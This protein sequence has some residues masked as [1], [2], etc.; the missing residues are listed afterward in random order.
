MNVS[1]QSTV[2]GV[3]HD[4]TQAQEAVRALKAAGF[5]DE[6]IG[7]VA[8]DGTAGTATPAAKGSHVTEG[9]VAGVAA[10]AGVGALWALGIAANVLP[11]IGPVISGGIIA[12]LL[13]SA[14]GGAAIAGIG[15][16]LVGLGIP[17]ADAKHYE[18]EF[19]AGRTL[20]TVRAEGRSAE[21]WT[22]MHRH[23]AYNR[24][25][26]AV[27]THETATAA[28]STAAGQTVRLHEEQLHATKTPVKTGEVHVHKEV[29][30]EQKNIRV[31]VTR[32]EVVIEHRSAS[33]RATGGTV[34]AE[35]IR[36]PVSEEQVH[37]RKDTV[38]TG[39]VSVGKR[40]V[41]D[42][43]QVSGTVRKEEVRVE[44]EGNVEVHDS[45]GGRGT[46]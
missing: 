12:S 38:V 17:E 32:E 14:A 15:G 39:E 42:T 10:G 36:I 2:V 44:K 24:Q 45:K 18:G 27:G 5:T 16:A 19:N 33:G 11:G 40:T 46:R 20:V 7:V 37:V 25:T 34:G 4:S 26:P 13:A 31:P 23:G 28:R 41:T 43:K 1:T 29:V 6:H 3:F 22:I 8:K 35:E 9:A 21:A 30:T